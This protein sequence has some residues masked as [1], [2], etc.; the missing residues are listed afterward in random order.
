MSRYLS[1]QRTQ[2]WTEI[3]SLGEELR[4]DPST[5][6][7]A[8]AVVD[9]TMMRARRNV[10][11]LIDR[12]PRLGY[13]FEPGDGLPVF[14]PPPSDI[15]ERLDEVEDSVGAIPLALRFWFVRVGR[16]NL[17]GRHPEWGY[18]YTDPLVVDAPP[19]YILS[20]FEAWK[21]DRDTEWDQGSF[22]INFAPDVLHKAEV[23]GGPPYSLAVPNGGADGL[24]LWETHQTTFVN[25][26]RLS[27]EWAGFPGWGV[28]QFGEQGT[29]E[30]PGWLGDLATQL[31]PI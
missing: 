21:A 16:V 20:E 13:V 4:A 12:L 23:S 8:T 28:D 19:D 3:T 25:L 1:G 9:E 15:G 6:A 7:E 18:S 30:P 17:T 5:L 26:M 31:E 29:A 10:E 22:R 27:F 2:V 24:V 11:R 14:E